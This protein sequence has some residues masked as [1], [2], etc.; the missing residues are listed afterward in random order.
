MGWN[1]LR[2]FGDY[3][4]YLSKYVNELEENM[5]PLFELFISEIN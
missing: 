2:S 4:E 1:I 5:I 3:P